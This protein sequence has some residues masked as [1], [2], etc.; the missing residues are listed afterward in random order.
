MHKIGQRLSFDEQ[1]SVHFFKNKVIRR[2]QR[3]AADDVSNKLRWLVNLNS[4]LRPKLSHLV[5]VFGHRERLIQKVIW[6]NVLATICHWQ[7]V[8]YEGHSINK[9]QN[10]I[11]LL[12]FK[13]WKFGNVR[14]V[15]N[16]IV[17][18]T[19]IFI[20]MM[21]SL[22]RHLYLEPSQSVQYFA[23]QLCFTTRKC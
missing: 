15:G 22:W 19:G 11:I 20:T 9:L 23:Q 21:S 13:I 5:S 8:Y 3:W 14:F 1:K 10:Y 4:R 6:P 18:H 2:I 7:L 17:A 16:L 12:I